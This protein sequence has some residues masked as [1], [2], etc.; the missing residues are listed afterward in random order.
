M[1]TKPLKFD[2][3]KALYPFEHKFLKLASTASLRS[4][5]S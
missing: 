2:V 1:M 5:V 4:I 3:N